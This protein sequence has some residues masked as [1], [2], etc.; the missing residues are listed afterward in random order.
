MARGFPK[1]GVP[2]LNPP[3]F[4]GILSGIFPNKKPTILTSF[5]TPSRKPLRRF[6]LP[7]RSSSRSSPGNDT[8]CCPPTWNELVY[9]SHENVINYSWV[10]WVVHTLNSYIYHKPMENSATYL[11]G[12]CYLGG[13]IL[14]GQWGFNGSRFHQVHPN[15]EPITWCLCHGDVS[16]RTENPALK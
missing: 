13:H 9:K 6:L 14:L 10:I 5:I 12:E 4:S 1:T 15:S 16:S 7:G 3:Y 2:P 11:S 8:G